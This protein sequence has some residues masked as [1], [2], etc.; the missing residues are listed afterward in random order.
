MRYVLMFGSLF[1][2]SP[3]LADGPAKRNVL[4]LVADDLGLDLGCYGNTAVKT[5]NLDALAAA[6]ARFP[7][8]FACVSSCSPSRAVLYTGLHTH[9][10]GQYGLAHAVHN[11]HTF[12]T[13]KSLP[14][15][16]NDA[17]YRTSI[18]G[19]EHVLPREVY[20]WTEVVPGGGRNVPQMAKQARKLM[21]AAGEKPFLIVMGFGDPHRAVKGFGDA[22]PGV[23]DVTFDPKDVFVPYHLPDNAIVRGELADYYRSVARLDYGVG[24][25][26]K[27]LHD[28]GRDADTLVIF[29]SDNGIP[30]PGAKTTLYDSG[31]NLPLIVKAPGKKPAV[32]NAMASWVDITPTILDWA[33]VAKPANLTG[34]SLLPILEQTDPTGW[35][36]VFASH[37]FHEVTMYYPMRMIRT[38]THKLI[39]NLAHPL[40]FPFASDLFESATW[41]DMRAR[42]AGMMGRRSVGQFVSRPREELYDLTADPEE[43]NNLNLNERYAGVLEDLRKRLR[44]WQEQTKDPWIIK[45][46]HE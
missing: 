3:V 20:P 35:D 13:V 18:I 14:K 38:R 19:K 7:N 8:G 25:V 10:S 34:R 43:L 45:Y 11:A 37:Q 5:P 30:F 31:L 32:C 23:P 16:L 26:L 29:V 22:V 2:C 27:E 6:G 44:A 28:A 12:N 36:E 9:A 15:L 33:G 4:L 21:D 46:Q 1:L 39:R 17:G 40:P 24:Q 41:Q 42:K